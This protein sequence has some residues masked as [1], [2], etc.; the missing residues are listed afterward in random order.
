MLNSKMEKW[1][2]S[3]ALLKANINT[4]NNWMVNTS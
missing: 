3:F 4:E 2:L 1:T